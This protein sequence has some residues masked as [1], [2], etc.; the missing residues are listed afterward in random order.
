MCVLI[1]GVRCRQ[2]EVLFPFHHL[3]LWALSS[4]RVHH[5]ESHLALEKDGVKRSSEWVLSFNVVVICSRVWTDSLKLR[6]Q[7]ENGGKRKWRSNTVMWL[8]AFFPDYYLSLL[9][10]I[11]ALISF[12]RTA[13]T[14]WG[15]GGGKLAGI[16]D[17]SG[18]NPLTLVRPMSVCR[19]P[20][21]SD[22]LR[23]AHVT[24]VAPKETQFWDFDEKVRMEML[25]YWR[26][27]LK[28][29]CKPRSWQESTAER[30]HLR[31][32]QQR[33]EQ[34]WEMRKKDMALVW[35]SL[36]PGHSCPSFQS[37]L[38]YTF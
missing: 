35:M 26:R 16:G 9:L 3:P 12:W 21:H 13:F 37:C 24:Q 11:I 25:S 27:R 36:V 6:F 29:E 23:D 1:Q 14:P 28:R 38:L 15:F 18:D 20:S 22:W 2:L 4:F 7:K 33:K 19:L 8:C 34:S 32:V 17:S 31:Q 10:P 30:S 5:L